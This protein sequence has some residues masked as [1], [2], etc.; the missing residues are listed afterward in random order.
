MPPPRWVSTEGIVQWGLHEDCDWNRAPWEA[1][2]NATDDDNG[3]A[4]APISP[5][6]DSSGDYDQHSPT[7]QVCLTYILVRTAV[8]AYLYTDDS[9]A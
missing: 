7:R 3:T 6:R 8:A 1:A 5:R 4:D 2:A 9:S